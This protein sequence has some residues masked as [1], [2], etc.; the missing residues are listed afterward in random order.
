MLSTFWFGKPGIIK[1]IRG[2]LQLANHP[3]IISQHMKFGAYVFLLDSEKKITSLLRHGT[4]FFT[5][6]HTI[7]SRKSVTVLEISTRCHPSGVTQKCFPVLYSYLKN[8]LWYHPHSKMYFWVT[9]L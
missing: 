6:E 2:L 3:S 4:V 7:I 5:S 9:E 1:D 8:H